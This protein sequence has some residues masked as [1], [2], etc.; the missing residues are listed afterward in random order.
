MQSSQKFT[1]SSNLTIE[2]HHQE[3]HGTSVLS[4][5]ESSTSSSL[6]TMT[7]SMDQSHELIPEAP[8]ADESLNVQQEIGEMTALEALDFL[9]EENKK[10]WKEKIKFENV[11][12]SE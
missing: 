5:S 9:I 11:S 1:A 8:V 3:Q 2:D 6:S 12:H 4:S 10:L 7:P